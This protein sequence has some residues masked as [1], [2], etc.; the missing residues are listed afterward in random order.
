MCRIETNNRFDRLTN[1]DISTHHKNTGFCFAKS[2]FLGAFGYWVIFQSPYSVPSITEA[3]IAFNKYIEVF[4]FK[5][6]EIVKVTQK[7][8]Q[9]LISKDV[10]ATI[11]EIEILN[12][13]KIDSGLLITSCSRY[14]TMKPDYDFID[15]GALAHNIRYMLMREYITQSL[16]MPDA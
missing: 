9:D 1:L 4:I 7:E 15:L 6:E 5:G 11:P 3:L 14:H 13:P 2:D 16:E 10:F 8:L 12:H